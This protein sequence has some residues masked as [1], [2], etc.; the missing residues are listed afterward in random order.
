M[1]NVSDE[2][3]KENQNAYCEFSE[4]FFFFFLNFAFFVKMWKNFLDP[5]TPIWPMRIEN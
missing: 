4:F 2:I 3:F 5:Q 1:R